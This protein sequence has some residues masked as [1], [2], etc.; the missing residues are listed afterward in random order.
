MISKSEKKLPWYIILHIII[1]FSSLSGVLSKLAS[2][3]A[4]LSPKFILLY[5]GIICV[6]G[7][8]AIAWQQVLKHIPLTTAFCNKAVNIIWGIIWGCLLFKETLKWNMI[9]GS[10]IVIIGV[11]IVVKS[12]EH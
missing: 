8:Y 3:A 7:V 1:L 5:G 9:A 11:I 6:L 2:G 10:V 4:F 12:D